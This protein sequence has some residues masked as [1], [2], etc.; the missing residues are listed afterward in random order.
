MVVS[1]QAGGLIAALAANDFEFFAVVNCDVISEVGSK[2][3]VMPTL[4]AEFPALQHSHQDFSQLLGFSIAGF[5]FFCHVVL[6]KN[7][8]PSPLLMTGLPG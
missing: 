1:F 5:L 4:Q 2:S 6:H 7:R 3:D 8:K